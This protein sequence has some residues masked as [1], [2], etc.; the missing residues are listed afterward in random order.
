[1]SKDDVIKKLLKNKAK[2]RT[3]GV[4]KLGL[5][6]SYISGKPT[7]KSDIDML[8]DFDKKTFDNYMGLKFFLEEQFNAKVD[9]VIPDS[10]KP[11]LKPLIL[12][13]AEYVKGL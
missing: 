2:I 10:L 3:F 7:K 4:K 9:L 11:Q 1:M 6:G 5:F 13:Q 12:K 8:V